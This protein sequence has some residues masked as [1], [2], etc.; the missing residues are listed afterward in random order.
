MIN[1][2][3]SINCSQGDVTSSTCC[4]GSTRSLVVDVASWYR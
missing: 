3:V 4:I 1:A 2:T